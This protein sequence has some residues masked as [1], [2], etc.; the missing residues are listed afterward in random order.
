MPKVNY[1]AN[2]VDPDE[3]TQNDLFCVTS[4]V[5]NTAI[6]MLGLSVN[7]TTLIV[8]K[9]RPPMQ[10]TSTMCTYFCQ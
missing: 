2:S 9:F 1:L 3:T 7:L 10:L 8:G 5:N 6:V 4:M